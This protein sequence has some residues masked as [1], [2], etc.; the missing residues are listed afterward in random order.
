[1]GLADHLVQRAWTHPLGEGLADLAALGASGE[2]VH[3][4]DK[5]APGN[6]VLQRD[7]QRSVGPATTPGP[8]VNPSPLW[9][10]LTRQVGLPMRFDPTT[11]RVLTVRD[12]SNARGTADATS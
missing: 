2:Q 8:I 7:T 5:K 6:E 12:L 3:G 1:M 9:R 4:D 10:R 11:F